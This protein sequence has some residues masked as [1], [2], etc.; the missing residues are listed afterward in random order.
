[1]S[2][3]LSGTIGETLVKD[4]FGI[5]TISRMNWKGTLP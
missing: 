1:M 3:F 2:S 5:Q 4:I